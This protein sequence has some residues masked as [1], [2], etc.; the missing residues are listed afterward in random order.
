MAILVEQVLNGMSDGR[1]LFP[2]AAGLSLVFGAM[3]LINP[4]GIS[5]SA[6]LRMHRAAGRIMSCSAQFSSS[7]P[8]LIRPN[9][10]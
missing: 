3:H 8:T 6:R 10:P 5:T 4:C 1:L 2:I 9:A 7:A